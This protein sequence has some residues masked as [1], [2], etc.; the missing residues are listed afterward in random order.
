MEIVRRDNGSE[1][2]GEAFKDVCR[3]LCMKRELTTANIIQFNEVAELTIG[4]I[5][6]TAN[7]ERIE[8]LL[9]FPELDIIPQT[10][11]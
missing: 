9:L 2:T 10:E 4:I 6:M 8:A 11:S 3:R 1:F 5:D 7:A